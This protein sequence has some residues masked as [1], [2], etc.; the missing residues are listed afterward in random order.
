MKFWGLGS[1]GMPLPARIYRTRPLSQ[2]EKPVAL[3]LSMALFFLRVALIMPAS[4]N[5]RYSRE[6]RSRGCQGG[7]LV[8]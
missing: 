5:A 6:A 3:P 8:A 1:P 4:S 2:A 7:I